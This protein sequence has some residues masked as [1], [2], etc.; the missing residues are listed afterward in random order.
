MRRI[1]IEWWKCKHT[2]VEL[3]REIRMIATKTVY[4]PE[5]KWAVNHFV[6]SK[7]F[8]MQ[9]MEIDEGK[10]KRDFDKYMLFIF[11]NYDI[12]EDNKILFK[13]WCTY[14]QYCNVTNLMKEAFKHIV[15]VNKKRRS[16]R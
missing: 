10:W 7:D 8:I 11:S 14:M 4:R 12:D 6:L 16:V 9:W 1:I 3:Q 13:N 15:E 5:F 2:A